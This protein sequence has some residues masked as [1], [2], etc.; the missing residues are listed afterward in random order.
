MYLCFRCTVS[1]LCTSLCVTYV[2]CW[3]IPLG[4]STGWSA[5]AAVNSWHICVTPSMSPRPW[6]P[7]TPAPNTDIRV[8]LWSSPTSHVVA[9]TYHRQPHC[10]PS[11]CPLQTDT[12]S[13]EWLV[14]RQLPCTKTM[15][16]LCSYIIMIILPGGKEY[17]VVWWMKMCP[18]L[19]EVMTMHHCYEVWV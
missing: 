8:I 1:G 4:S 2:C 17:L 16:K 13:D 6:S 11:P 3:A 10:T 15:L 7:S 5:S 19:Y 9:V 18:V 14:P 12:M